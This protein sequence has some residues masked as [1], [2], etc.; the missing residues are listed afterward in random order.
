MQQVKKVKLGSAVCAF[1]KNCIA[2]DKN[3]GYGSE[4]MGDYACRLGKLQRVAHP[5][6]G[7]VI[8][9]CVEETPVD[10]ILNLITGD[11]TFKDQNESTEVKIDV[12]YTECEYRQ[13]YFLNKWGKC[14]N[15][16]RISKKEEKKR[17]GKSSDH[18]HFPHYYD[19]DYEKRKKRK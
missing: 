14:E 6:T 12:D 2:T 10:E 15:Y 16:E 7:Q 4:Y 11:G 17:F 3:R 13:C 8:Y 5:V 1:C 19:K 9:I 18:E